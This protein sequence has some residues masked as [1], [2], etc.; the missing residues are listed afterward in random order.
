MILA[1]VMALTFVSACSSKEK[2]VA[3]TPYPELM[4]LSKEEV[5][6]Q[7]EELQAKRRFPKARAYYSYV[8]E[9]F[10]NDPLG[11]RALLKIADTYFDQGDPVNLVEAQYKY[12]DFINRY[13][14]SDMAAY[15]MYQIANVAYEQMERPDRDQTRT[16]EAVTKFREMLEAYP[17]SEFRPE[18]EKRLKAAIDNLGRHEHVVARFYMHRRSWNAAVSR[19]NWLLDQYPDYGSRDEVFFDL[20][21]SLSELGR[22]GEARLYYERVIA[23]FPESTLARQ[24][25]EKLEDLTT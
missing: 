7:A 19:L 1:V 21:T 15:A 12:R 17:N 9:N 18:A 5:F 20:A 13:P 14:G 16:R 8:Y 11:R 24:A 3:A 10:P 2:T 23:E 25:K 6:A 22:K 4:S